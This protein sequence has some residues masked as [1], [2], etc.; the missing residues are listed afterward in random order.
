MDMQTKIEQLL[1]E[2]NK[3]ELAAI[4]YNFDFDWV[5][6]LD[7]AE[8]LVKLQDIRGQEYLKKAL[9]S[10]NPDTREI[11]REIMT[12]LNLEILETID[13][14][15]LGKD[16]QSGILNSV[17]I[18]SLYGKIVAIIVVV[19]GFLIFLDSFSWKAGGMNGLWS[20][21][22]VFL[23]ILAITITTIAFGAGKTTQ[24]F[25]NKS[26]KEEPIKNTSRHQTEN[27][28]TKEGHDQLSYFQKYGN[29]L[30]WFILAIAII[31]FSIM[32]WNTEQ[33][34]GYGY[35][36]FLT[37]M[38]ITIVIPAVIVIKLAQLAKIPKYKKRLPLIIA[39]IVI[40]AC[41]LLFS[42]VTFIPFY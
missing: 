6:Q 23:A 13:E 41:C 15:S 32:G 19:S 27:T 28:S 10:E 14:Q 8:A 30:P 31:V 24:Y 22:V 9:K 37:V 29:R 39:S 11:A 33:G 12:E 25:L 34:W 1:S 20:M 16:E 17:S 4:M 36:N 2:S 18:G 3:D 40:S 5:Y 21:I 42:V 26:T 38:I 7:A 35:I